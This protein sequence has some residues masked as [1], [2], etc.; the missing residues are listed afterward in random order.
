MIDI[1]TQ[2]S[3]ISQM[4]KKYPAAASSKNKISKTLPRKSGSS[5]PSSNITRTEESTDHKAQTGGFL[6][7]G[8]RREILERLDVVTRKISSSLE[9]DEV[10]D[11][12]INELK[13]LFYFEGFGILLVDEKKEF[14]LT[15]KLVIP[16]FAAE[17]IKKLAARKIPLN[18]EEGGGVALAV[19]KKMDMYFEDVDPAKL[20]NGVNKEAVIKTGGIKS[21]LIMPLSIDK[22]VVGVMIM[23]AYSRNLGFSAGDIAT[24]RRF[25]EHISVAIKN[26]FLHRDLKIALLELKK[27]NR[28]LEKQ[29][30]RLG[31]LS[32][33]DSL[34]G[35][36]NRRYF[37]EHIV[38]ELEKCKR[39]NK[40]IFVMM[41]DIDD[42][43]L[44][45]DTYG[46]DCGDYVLIKLAQILRA[47]LRGS[48]LMARYGGE[49]FIV[50][51]FETN[52]AGALLA[53]EK[54]RQKMEDTI[55]LY[56][57]NKISRTVSIGI[58]CY[59]PPS[60]AAVVI[61]DVVREADEAL[62]R[63]KKTGKNKCVY[64]HDQDRRSS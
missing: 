9:L 18:I 40:R 8:K 13:K 29:K 53:A 60:G 11:V 25:V 47:M 37:D 5:S 54:V 2:L 46:H 6:P 64:Y 61:D 20:A 1:S 10:L 39:Y 62:Y 27:A 31:E 21:A 14:L 42:F 35:I 17:E 16:N 48:D 45:N 55:Y 22:E 7:P 34:T 51:M 36:R 30:Q 50:A 41:I 24:I 19:L 38:L 3:Y 12:T 49:E 44:V 28:K 52:A 57:R 15:L 63:A 26:S 33:T 56:R 32:I 59:P 4:M 43:K 58:S 23:S